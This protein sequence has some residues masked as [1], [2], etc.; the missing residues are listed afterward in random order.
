[1]S[2]DE[3]VVGNRALEPLAKVAYSS[4]VT[5]HIWLERVGEF[6]EDDAYRH[7]R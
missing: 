4:W 2:R 7:G 6:S 5:K 1:M 3:A